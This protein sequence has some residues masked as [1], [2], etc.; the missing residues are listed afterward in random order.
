MSPIFHSVEAPDM[1]F[2]PDDVTL[3]DTCGDM[4]PDEYR[5]SVEFTGGECPSC[6]GYRIVHGYTGQVGL[7]AVLDH[8]EES[9]A[10]HPEKGRE[11]A[12]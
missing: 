3:C 4:T 9:Y 8:W 2:G 7:S 10:L 5:N 6:D 12:L 1:V 11:V